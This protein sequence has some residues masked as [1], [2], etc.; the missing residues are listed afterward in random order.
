I[1]GH[2][3]PC[4]IARD[5]AVRRTKFGYARK[6][7][8]KQRPH[9]GTSQEMADAQM[10]PGRERQ[11]LT[12]CAVQVDSLRV[13]ILRL[14]MPRHRQKVEQHLTLAELHAELLA[15]LGDDTRI[16]DYAEQPADLF[17]RISHLVGFMAQALLQV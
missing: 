7:F 13:R 2:D 4:A 8:R 14:V 3:S 12:A 16:V 6:P 17:D 11:M 1:A 9:F 10:W 15:I 5:E